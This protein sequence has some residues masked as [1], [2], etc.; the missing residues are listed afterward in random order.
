LALGYL[1]NPVNVVAAAPDP[2]GDQIRVVGDWLPARAL[3]S[4]GWRDLEFGAVLPFG[5]GAS[6]TGLAG[7]TTRTEASSLS[8]MGAPRLAVRFARRF[9]NFQLAA[10]EQLVLPLAATGTF[11]GSNGFGYAPALLGQWDGA[12]AW[13]S[14]SLGL[15][16]ARS[17]AFGPSRFGSSAAL[18]MNTGVHVSQRVKLFAETLV[19][20]A[21]NE[22]DFSYPSAKRYSWRI[23]AELL[24]GARLD[25]SQLRVSLGAGTS[26]PLT[27]E[28][29]EYADGSSATTSRY[30]AP[31]SPALR[32]ELRVETHWQ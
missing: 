3:F 18:A 17:S 4:M 15:R 28:H 21:L 6:G 27:R 10:T 23:P 32:I 12:R 2:Y 13:L 26:L 22:D 20:P 7:V 5:F 31:P 8:G 25:T 9:G 29:V 30:A 14:A 1:R 11:L 19:L 16:L 24:L